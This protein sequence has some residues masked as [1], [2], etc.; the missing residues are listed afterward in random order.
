MS[1]VKEIKKSPNFITVDDGSVR[2]PIN[3]LQGEEIGIFYFRPT[4]L[5]IIERYNKFAENFDKITEPLESLNIKAD[6]TV[7]ENNEAEIKALAE[8]TK[9]LY[10][11][12]NE[13]FGGD[14]S[15]AF[16]G[17]M[18]PF[19]PIGGHFYCQKAL[20]AVGAYISNQF[21][22]EIKKV[23]SRVNKYIHGYASRTGKHKDG[24]K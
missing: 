15:S 6:G 2:V 12:C 20:E 17:K 4:D 5:G 18:N 14:M 1:E 13:L 7:D 16:F 11:A 3:N 22:S 8:A 23:N 21:N 10:N 9:R 19:S 24:K